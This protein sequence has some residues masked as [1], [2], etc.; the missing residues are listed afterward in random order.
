MGGIDKSFP[1]GEFEVAAS[2]ALMNDEAATI[3]FQNEADTKNAGKLENDE[4]Q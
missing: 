2:S 4:A 3:E 1:R